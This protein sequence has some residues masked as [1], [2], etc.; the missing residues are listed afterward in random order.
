M[1]HP[2]FSFT[3]SYFVIL[4]SSQFSGLD[5]L[6]AGTH[7]SSWGLICVF[8]VWSPSLTWVQDAGPWSARN[9]GLQ[10]KAAVQGM[11][12]FVVMHW[13]LMLS[14]C[15]VVEVHK[16]KWGEKRKGKKLM[17]FTL[18]SM[19]KRIVLLCDTTKVH[20]KSH[21]WHSAPLV[22]SLWEVMVLGCSW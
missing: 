19:Q 13:C 1:I 17:L 5:H 4:C 7:P 10:T 2:S 22:K 21:V 11:L 8:V 12:I 3:E 14:C 9:N 6:M 20:S 16:P 18:Q 15:C